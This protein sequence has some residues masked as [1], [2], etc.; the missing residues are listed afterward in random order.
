[1]EIPLEMEG[2]LSG[3]TTRKPTWEEYQYQVS[4]PRLKLTSYEP[5]KPTSDHF[6]VEEQRCIL[7]IR[8]PDQVIDEEELAVDNQHRYV[9]AAKY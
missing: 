6:A 3:F 7:S 5:W 4:F 2:I 8:H 9:A 1:M